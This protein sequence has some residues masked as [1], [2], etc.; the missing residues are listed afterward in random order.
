MGESEGEGLG[1]GAAVRVLGLDDHRLRLPHT[2]EGLG[3]HQFGHVVVHIQQPHMND[4]LRQ[5]Y[6]II[7]REE[8]ESV[9]M[10]R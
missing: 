6:R 7:L 1:E 5:L 8:S 9:E 10:P 3:L 2:D 4:T